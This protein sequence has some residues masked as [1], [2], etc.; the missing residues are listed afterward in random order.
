MCSHCPGGWGYSDVL[1]SW[2]QCAGG[3]ADGGAGVGGGDVPGG[4]GEVWRIADEGADFRLLLCG[5][6]RYL[7]S[8][9]HPERLLCF[10][11]KFFT[12]I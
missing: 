7:L 12:L 10:L 6:P 11:N 4:S 8:F 1:L 5:G 3:G 2:S 9:L